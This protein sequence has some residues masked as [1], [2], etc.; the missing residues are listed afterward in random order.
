MGLSTRVGGEVK[1]RWLCDKLIGRTGE[2][3]I[4]KKFLLFPK[5]L[6]NEWRWLE[7]TSILQR[8]IKMDVGGSYEWGSYKNKWRYIKWLS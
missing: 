4:V 1:M 8:I 6:R 2:E 3:R 5:R 7:K